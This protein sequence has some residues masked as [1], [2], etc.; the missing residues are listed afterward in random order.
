MY[1]AYAC[2]P[3]ATVWTIAATTSTQVNPFMTFEE[4]LDSLA[5]CSLI[6]ANSVDCSAVRSCIFAVYRFVR[7]ADTR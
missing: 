3:A 4:L 2:I 7:I 1:V 6:L 5:A